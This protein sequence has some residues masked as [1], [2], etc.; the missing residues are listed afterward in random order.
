MIIKKIFIHIPKNAGM[1]I[2]KSR[3]LRDKIVHCW[4]E[5]AQINRIHG[6]CVRDYE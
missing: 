3:M 5:F 6:G 2:R 1:T 4:Y